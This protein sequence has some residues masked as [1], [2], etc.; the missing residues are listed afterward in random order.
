[1]FT[2][3]VKM[4]DMQ[5][6]LDNTSAEL[7]QE[8]NKDT[9]VEQYVPK[10]AILD[11]KFFTVIQVDRDG[12]KIK[13]RCNT[14]PSKTVISGSSIALSNFTTHLKVGLTVY[15]RSHLTQNSRII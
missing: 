7:D 11:G 15:P 5:D 10:S 4:A 12:I 6:K 1:M 9:S 8:K 3:Q 13:A 2:L 14:C